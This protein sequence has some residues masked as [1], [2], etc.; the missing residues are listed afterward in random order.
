[1]II[2]LRLFFLDREATFATIMNTFT[3][4]LLVLNKIHSLNI[5]KAIYAWYRN[6]GAN[7]LMP[8]DFLSYAFC[9][10]MPVCRAFYGLILTYGIMIG[11]FQIAQNY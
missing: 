10:A 3:R 11:N 8:F 9:L 6:I 2:L 7:T 4:L 1:M 5:L